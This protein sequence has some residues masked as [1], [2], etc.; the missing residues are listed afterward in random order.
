[1]ANYFSSVAGFSVDNAAGTLTDISG[2]VPNLSVSGGNELVDDTGLGDSVRHE[3]TGISP[4]NEMS[5]TFFVNSTTRAIF[6]P[7][8]N[9][10]SV[11]KT[12]QAQLNTSMYLSGESNVST[13][14]FSSPIGLQTGTAT[15]RSSDS[16]GF[17]STS[18]AL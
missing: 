8:V 12:V 16:S 15:F 4:V 14:S 13:V 5:I 3:A 10:T 2:Y 1:M 17:S 9:G 11:A 7:L 18:V 6:A